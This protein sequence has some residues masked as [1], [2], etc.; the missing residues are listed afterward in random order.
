V[1]ILKIVGCISA[2]LAINRPPNT[3]ILLGEHWLTHD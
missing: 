2:M 1:V 3:N